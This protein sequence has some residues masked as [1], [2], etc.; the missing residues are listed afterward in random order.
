[1]FI[2]VLLPEPEEPMIATNSLASMSMSTL[3]R[4]WIFS[5]PTR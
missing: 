2:S 4:A 1:M 3:R 5:T